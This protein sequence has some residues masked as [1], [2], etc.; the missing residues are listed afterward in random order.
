[1]KHNLRLDY[2]RLADT[3]RDKQLVDP[4]AL[5]HTLHQAQ[6]TGALFTELLVRDGLLTDWELCR[7][8]SEVFNLAF[9]PVDF[10]E[11][12][13][14]LIARFD[15]EFLRQYGLVP[16]DCFGSLLTVAMPGMV[17][18]E[19]LNEVEERLSVTVLPVVGSVGGN[20]AWLDRHL[21][22]NPVFRKLAEEVAT[23][24]WGELFDVGDAAVQTDLS[25]AAP[26]FEV[27]QVEP[28][29]ADRPPPA[30]P[31]RGQHHGL[32]AEAESLDLDLDLG[33]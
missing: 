25:G 27:L 20:Q 4:E 1:V 32:P 12:D 19:I 3:I 6:A 30:M 29:D 9:L 23:E 16:L 33:R 28:D 5:R 21:P 24:G 17:P 8:A 18:T 31:S 22:A 7:L 26:N 13:K 14:D 15:P 11:P 2:E 10:Y